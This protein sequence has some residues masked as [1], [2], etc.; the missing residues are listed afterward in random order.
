M[1]FCLEVN[2]NDLPMQFKKKKD[3]EILNKANII[4]LLVEVNNV[5]VNRRFLSVCITLNYGRARFDIRYFDKIVA[6]KNQ[7]I[8]RKKSKFTN[9]LRT[10]FK[11][12]I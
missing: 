7:S 3:L 2:I 9:V 6:Y 4:L 1:Q 10:N 12:K 5:K 11:Q 8:F